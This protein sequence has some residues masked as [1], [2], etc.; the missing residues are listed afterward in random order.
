MDHHNGQNKKGDRDGGDAAGDAMTIADDVD[1]DDMHPP[2][3]L[4]PAL[5]LDVLAYMCSFLTTYELTRLMATSAEMASLVLALGVSKPTRDLPTC[6]TEGPLRGIYASQYMDAAGR[7]CHRAWRVVHP[8]SAPA[9][10]IHARRMAPLGLPATLPLSVPRSAWC[11]P[12]P[13]FAQLCADLVMCFALVGAGRM[14]P[15]LP[16]AAAILS[17]PLPPGT[18]VTLQGDVHAY[19]VA[20]YGDVFV[21]MERMEAAQAAR[22]RAARRWEAFP[23][24]AFAGPT[25]AAARIDRTGHVIISL[26]QS[27]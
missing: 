23:Q 6:P 7:P 10:R 12:R 17:E 2:A 20:S 15:Y 11:M 19:S 5:P 26:S 21:H 14:Q 25:G 24:E 8:A 1:D 22:A 27:P 3:L 18:L 4:L 16:I 13:P 9:H